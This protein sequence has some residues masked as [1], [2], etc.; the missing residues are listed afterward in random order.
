M[1]SALWRS[2]RRLT[3]LTGRLSVSGYRG[4]LCRTLFRQHTLGCTGGGMAVLD[5]AV[6]TEASSSGIS[7]DGGSDLTVIEFGVDPIS[8]LN[9]F[10]RSVVVW[11]R[12]RYHLF[13][14]DCARPRSLPIS[15]AVGRYV[16][17]L[18]SA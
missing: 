10:G 11:Q 13:P 16:P 8:R 1:H 6:G 4:G 15:R 5:A 17:R 2:S 9:S 7:G 14:V 18:L 12:R 3:R